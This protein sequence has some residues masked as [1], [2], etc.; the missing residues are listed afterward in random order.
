MHGALPALG[1]IRDRLLLHVLTDRALSRGRT[2]PEVAA[3]AL[4]G[5]A[6]V[7][8]LRGKTLSGAELVRA[9][10]QLRD[11]T[12]VH[13]GLLIV[14]DRVDVALAVDAD[15]AHVGQDDLLA[16]DARRLLGSDRLLGV[17]A[18]S[19]EEAVRAQRDGAD[20]IG[21]GP[22]FST[23]TKEDAGAPSGLDELRRASRA[24]AIPV[25]AI[26]GIT[27]HNA[28]LVRAAGA[29]GV[30]VISAVV[31]APDIAEATRTLRRAIEGDG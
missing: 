6:T 16:R 2:D 30:A 26:G 4:A 22:V 24:V 11:L 9:G 29:A 10:R 23:T 13:G 21:F 1:A 14:N 5:G 7:V 28:G 3:A 27:P 31:G 12:R 25:V 15:G 18:R 20:Y 8:Q 19:V 17:S